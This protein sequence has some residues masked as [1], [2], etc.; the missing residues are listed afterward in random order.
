M[1]FSC[2]QQVLNKALNIVSKAVTPRTTIPLQKGILLETTNDGFLKLTASDTDLTIERNIEAVIYEH[3]SAVVSSRLFTDIIRKLPGEKINIEEEEN[4]TLV[5]RCLSSEFKIVGQP[6]EGFNILSDIDK[7]EI[8]V[9]N[10]ELFKEMIRK[11]VFAAS[12]DE[13]K[14]VITGVLIEMNEESLTLVALDG[15]RMAVVTERMNNKD[16]KGIIVSSRILA[17]IYKI[18][19]DME[20]EDDIS[21]VLEDKKAV[22]NMENTR[23]ALRLMEGT[24]IKFKDIIPKE[25]QC[26]IKAKKEELLDSIERASLM[27]KDGKNNLIKFSIFRDK[28]IITSR[29]EEGNVKEEI[30]VEKNGTDLE[31]G[32]NAKY[33]TDALKVINDDEILL[34][35]NTSVNPCLITPIEGDSYNYLILPVRIGAGQ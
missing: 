16:D 24:F 7:G 5:I 35:F 17:E 12:I 26:V 10:K 8:I 28:I 4:N 13:A 29:S 33:M 3:G 11:T 2:N 9:L 20:T 34:K 27:A 18:L 21:L 15:F 25:Y 23:I 30:F 31:I 6:S 1:K 22:I 14:G 19:S 32:F